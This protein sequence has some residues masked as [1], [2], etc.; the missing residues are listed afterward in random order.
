ME[1]KQCKQIPKFYNKSL[2]QKKFNDIIEFK[3][4]NSLEHCEYVA[5]SYY[6]HDS[7]QNKSN[8]ENVIGKR[9]L[10]YEIKKYIYESTFKCRTYYY[11]NL[12]LLAILHS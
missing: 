6:Y 9:N 1:D 5:N 4:N 11:N 12:I 10:T 7:A 8:K 3:D 2:Q